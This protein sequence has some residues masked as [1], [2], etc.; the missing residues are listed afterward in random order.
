V[1]LKFS[2]AWQV[3]MPTNKGGR[4]P[5]MVEAA[6]EGSLHG[7]YVF[8]E[9]PATSEPNQAK[10]IASLEKLDFLAVQ[11]I[12]LTETA[13]LA[14]VVLPATTF[15][16]KD[17]T[18]TNTERRVQRV[19][20]AIDPPGQA[21]PDWQILSLLSTAMGHPMSYAH[22]GEIFD[23]MASLT[24]SYGGM[25]YERIDE[26]G[27]Q[28]PCPTPDHPGTR[29]L[30][31][32]QF[33][34]GLG[35][36]QEISFRPAA[37]LPDEEYPYILSTGRTLYNYNIGNMTQKAGAIR[38]KQGRNFVELH[39]Q[40]AAALGVADG[41]E[42]AVAT[43]RGEVVVQARVGRR[44]RPG[45]LWMP[46]HFAEQP[47]NRITN[48]A[49]DNVTRTAEYKVCAARVVKAAPASASGSPRSATPPGGTR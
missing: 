23:E 31:E 12:F 25:S 3:E 45:A 18:F 49:F 19:R 14:D 4:I 27:L 30:H 36:F 40:D 16:E 13:K 47:T 7:L 15:A 20:K 48:D 1:R 26:V 2:E 17:G 33:T 44:T 42:V 35:A 24:P 9:D 21:K 38:Q 11:E 46:F 34:R 41:D 32:G 6:E 43:R 28:W 39:E 29:F 8:G 22:A 37:E 5:D 10:V